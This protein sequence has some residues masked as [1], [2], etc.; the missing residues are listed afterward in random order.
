MVAKSE[1]DGYTILA[2]SAAHTVNPFLYR[3]LPYDSAT[4]FTG[5]TP[6][7]NLP[8]ILVVS[9]QSPINSV[10]ELIAAAKK[11]PG[12]LNYASAGTGS[13]THMNAEKFRI[14]S[15]IVAEHIAFK[16]TPEGYENQSGR[17]VG[18]A[19]RRAAIRCVSSR[20]TSH[21]ASYE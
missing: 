20:K 10:Q 15:G 2:N 1:P 8:N 19:L 17:E 13:G 11:A 16:G 12:K 14:A 7:A 5:V 3:N 21:Y 9:P 18:T 4:D 6:L